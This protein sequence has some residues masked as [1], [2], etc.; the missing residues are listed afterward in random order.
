MGR[1][2]IDVQIVL[3]YDNLIKQYLRCVLDWRFREPGA[4]LE[5]RNKERRVKSNARSIVVNLRV[6]APAAPV[7][8]QIVERLRNAIIE[9]YFEPGGRLVERELCELM[10]VSRTSVREALRQLE[11]EGLITLIPNAG[12]QVA[13]LD[14]EDVRQIYQ[15]RSALE[16]LSVRLFV[17]NASDRE[18]KHLKKTFTEM[19]SRAQSENWTGF[20]NAQTK[21]YEILATGA[22]NDVL[23]HQLKLL[24]ARAALLR[25]RLPKNRIAES[26]E[27]MSQTIRLIDAKDETAAEKACI[28]HIEKSATAA[29][30]LL[31]D[32]RGEALAERG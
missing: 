31:A 3:L 15:V 24:R 11:A 21:L 12:P 9:C 8:E 25:E 14:Q 23:A 5:S 7:R 18:V 27:E 28:H 30:A 20:R 10:G 26:L 6:V 17:Q 13:R 32:D 29:L 22:R 16:G 2:S 1:C 19:E 4:P